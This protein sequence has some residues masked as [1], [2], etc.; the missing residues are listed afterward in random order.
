[1][2]GRRT[3]RRIGRRRFIGAGGAL[4]AAAVAP[5]VWVPRE[6]R[7]TEGFGTIKHLLYVRL[8][9]GFRFPV[10]FNGDLDSQY[11]P[12]GTTSGADGTEWGPGQLLAQNEWLTEE[13]AAV[14]LQPVTSFT[15]DMAVIGTVDHE[16]LSGSADGN[17][18][19]A[20]ERY[21]TGYVNG[22]NG[23]FTM[24]NFGLR[25][26]T[27][28]D[29]AEGIIKLPAIVKGEPAIGRSTGEYG[30][31][32][33][34]VLRGDDLDRFAAGA[35][36]ALPEWARALSEGRDEKLAQV[37]NDQHFSTVDA[38]IQSREA[39]KAYSEIFASDALKI[40]QGGGEMIDGITNDE[41]A[42]AFGDSGEGRNAHLALRLFHFGCPAVYFDQG[43]YDYHS[44]EEEELPMR[45][46]GMNRLLS[47]L[48][49]ALKRMEH[50]EG[51]TYWDHTVVVLGSEFS[52][53]G[54][55]ARFNS[56]QGSDHNGDNATRYMCMPF[57]GG[58]IA[59]KG[60]LIGPTDP[61]TMEAVDKVY[62]YRSMWNTIMDGLGAET[63]EFFPAD[64][65]FDDLYI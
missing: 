62:S 28:M 10:A 30:A 52:R 43:G 35:S 38:Y 45:I 7:A 59:A 46:Q 1:M 55:G 64:E 9:G 23:L 3:I 22:A 42:A 14:G 31:F 15:N 11:N 47:A 18:Q 6:V 36:D 58:P 51:G 16:P 54:R 21:A 60:R 8:S 56:A 13:V 53:T 29:A 26:Q 20:L 34:A 2:A 40:G 37:V 44:D 17:H 33:P 63:N 32:R 19:T 25:E 41:L 50:P 5:W 27:M 61:S 49:W 57:M 12:F 39:T 24:L 48:N 4:A 65:P